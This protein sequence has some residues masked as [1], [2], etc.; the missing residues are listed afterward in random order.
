[1]SASEATPA[2][3][4]CTIMRTR[5]S[6][7]PMSTGRTWSR[8]PR[9][10]Q[11]FPEGRGHQRDIG[12][13]ERAQGAERARHVRA[14]LPRRDADSR[15]YQWRRARAR[16]GGAVVSGALGRGAPKIREGIE[17]RERGDEGRLATEQ[18]ADPRHGRQPLGLQASVQGREQF[19]VVVAG[20][21]IGVKQRHGVE[22][23][24]RQAEG[25]GGLHHWRAAARGQGGKGRV[26]A[27]HQV[28]PRVI[29]KGAPGGERRP[30][31]GGIA[32]AELGQRIGEGGRG[33]D[34]VPR[35]WRRPGPGRRGEERYAR[36]GEW[37]GERA[38]ANGGHHVEAL[39]PQGIGDEGQACGVA[40]AQPLFPGQQHASAPP[41]G[42][43]ARGLSGRCNHNDI[44]DRGSSRKVSQN[45]IWFKAPWRRGRQH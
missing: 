13:G 16:G 34:V 23:G 30:H 41:G 11:P 19:A 39:L 9:R 12:F 6:V 29:E 27:D 2:L 43:G 21:R 1:M 8:T 22:M 26:I 3:P 36:F 5:A 15:R 35:P 37:C 7:S 20:R 28:R 18:V 42:M 33:R 17:Q 14:P 10:A 40:E 44:P 24:G 45:L 32:E 4:W 38:V 25:V 31:A